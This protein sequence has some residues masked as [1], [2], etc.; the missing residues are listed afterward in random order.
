LSLERLASP[1]Q[2]IMDPIE[3]DRI[4]LLIGRSH[5]SDEDG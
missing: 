4:W 3:G 1:G 2:P 5:Q